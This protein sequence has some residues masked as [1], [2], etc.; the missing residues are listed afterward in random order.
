MPVEQIES[1]LELAMQQAI[2]DPSSANLHQLLGRL[3]QAL[4][5]LPQESQLQ[6]A[7][8]ILAQLVDIYAS[9]ANCLLEEWEEKYNPAQGEPILT[10]KLLHEVLRQTMTLNLDEVLEDAPSWQENP[11][12]SDSVVGAVDQSNLLEFLAQMEQEQAKQDALA[13]AHDEDI[14]AWIGK[15]SQWMNEHQNKDVSLFELQRSLQMPFIE[16]WLA[17]LLGGYV[18]E[19]RGDFYQT[20]GVWVK[21]KKPKNI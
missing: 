11:S 18:I 19:Q 20:E 21:A 4:I 5:D 3:E 6:V 10:A 13:V 17:L 1:D 14:S 7:G 12:P 15:I 8:T 9:R 2:A 16:I